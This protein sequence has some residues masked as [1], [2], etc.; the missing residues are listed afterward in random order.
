MLDEDYGPSPYRRVK[1]S[2]TACRSDAMA[3]ASS[4]VAVSSLICRISTRQR[5]IVAG[6]GENRHGLRCLCGAFLRVS[7]PVGR[8]PPGLLHRGLPAQMPPPEE[9]READDVRQHD[10]RGD[11]EREQHAALRLNDGQHREDGGV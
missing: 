8:L 11:L 9:D 4:I 2:A 10:E 6:R 1:S 5:I 7:Q 3:A